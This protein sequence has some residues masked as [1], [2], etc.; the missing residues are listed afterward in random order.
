MNIRYLWYTEDGGVTDQAAKVTHAHSLMMVDVQLADG[1]HRTSVQVGPG[2]TAVYAFIR[3]PLPD[4]DALEQAIRENSGVGEKG[5][6]GDS[7]GSS[8]DG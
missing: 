3:H 8:G 1:T 6:A 2:G 5:K 4:G 7:D